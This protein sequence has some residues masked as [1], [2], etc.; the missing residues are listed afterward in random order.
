[1]QVKNDDLDFFDISD[2]DSD[3]EDG[4]YILK[5]ES[6]QFGG[7]HWDMS[8][9]H[10]KYV[11]GIYEK[12]NG[13]VTLWEA[14]HLF[15]LEPTPDK[16]EN[17]TDYIL[18]ALEQRD[19]KYVSFFLHHYEKAINSMIWK[20]LVSYGS[21]VYDPVTQMNLKLACQEVILKKLLTFDP[22]AGKEFQKYISH[23]LIDAILKQ[24]MI[25]EQWSFSSLSEYKRVRRIGAIYKSCHESIPDTIKKFCKK[26]GCTPRTAREYLAIAIGHRARFLPITKE[27]ENPDDESVEYE[28]P[29]QSLEEY[30]HIRSDRQKKEKLSE[31]IR[32]AF[33]EL[34]PKEQFL[35]EKHLGISI[36][37]NWAGEIKDRWTFDELADALEY[38]TA[39]GTERA[40]KNACAHF[41]KML[42][43]KNVG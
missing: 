14:Q 25:E 39:K 42:I 43:G 24:I 29:G 37:D 19:L 26:D 22:N 2:E 31:M 18:Q 27:S 10:K 33:A 13:E 8:G 1:M 3:S 12:V 5:E 17:L 30:L 28:I 16:P 23:F 34:S 35:L 7:F 41:Q 32:A 11:F 20:Y 38:G 40:Y 6:R 4:V 21:K 36:K 15:E 9:Y